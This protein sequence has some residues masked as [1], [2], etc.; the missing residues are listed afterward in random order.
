MIKNFFSK[1]FSKFFSRNPNTTISEITVENVEDVGE[2]GEKIDTVKLQLYTENY[3][4]ITLSSADYN[5]GKFTFKLPS[6]GDEYLDQIT[7]IFP[8]CI[9][10]HITNINVKFNIL[11]IDLL[12]NGRHIG[13]LTHKI[14]EKI[15]GDFIYVDE[16]V[17][18]T[19]Y[20]MK[21]KY[22]IHLKRGWNIMFSTENS[23]TT[24]KT[25]GLKWYLFN[26]V[27]VF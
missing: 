10:S 2:Y 25:D 15:G 5:G 26:T 11:F 24:R 1:L 13:I 8:P 12:G 9:T 18:V 6:V 16:D 3:G 7:N 20:S 17:S 21:S 19:G 14:P 4:C 27:V 22:D 23:I